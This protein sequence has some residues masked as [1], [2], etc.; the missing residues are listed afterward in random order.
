MRVVKVRLGSRSY[1]IRIGQGMLE[2]AGLLLEGLG[3]KDRAVIITHPNLK[4]LYGDTL[5]ESLN[6]RGFKTTVLEVPEG[7]EQKSLDT[8]GRLYAELTD[9][10]AERTTPIL[11]LGGGVI[12]D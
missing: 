1:E 4:K 5:Q 2:E 3:F 7:E 6:S 12:G 8:A 11:A 9:V 10:F